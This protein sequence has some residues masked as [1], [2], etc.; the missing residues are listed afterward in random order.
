MSQRPVARGRLVGPEG[1]PA[2]PGPEPPIRF[3][4][5]ILASLLLAV[6]LGVAG[7]SYLLTLRRGP[8]RTAEASPRAEPRHVPPPTRLAPDPDLRR[9]A[10]PASVVVAPQE[11]VRLAIALQNLPGFLDPDV[12][13]VAL[14][15]TETGADFRWLPLS[16]CRAGAVL[17]ATSTVVGSLTITVATSREHARHGYLVRKA[18]RFGRARHEVETLPLDAAA[19]RVQF[20][21]ANATHAAGPLQIRRIDDPSWQASD[22]APTGLCCR[23]KDAVEVTLGAGNY[24]LV[25]PI[26]PSIRQQFTVPAPSPVQITGALSR[27]A[28]GRP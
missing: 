5:T 21:L 25:D 13:G 6:G 14:F 8:Q 16:A 19:Q 10:V 7:Y 18:H 22:V 11:P 24:E 2:P 27:P 20:V 9:E 4:A 28:A 3:L 15:A 17:E 1:A 23:G 26:E 12:A